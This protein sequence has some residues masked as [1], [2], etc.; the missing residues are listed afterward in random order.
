MSTKT[1]VGVT[2]L[3]LG[4]GTLI[5]SPRLFRNEG[6]TLLLSCTSKQM[7]LIPS[8][9]LQKESGITAGF[10]TPESFTSSLIA[11]ATKKAKTELA[12]NPLVAVSSVARLAMIQPAIKVL[13]RQAVYD[14]CEGR[15]PELKKIVD[16]L[17]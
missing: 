6:T 10:Y 5:V 2:A 12:G 7:Y 17:Q 15:E 16:Y 14:V 13:V 9:Q 3:A 8:D 1:V 4:V 11:E